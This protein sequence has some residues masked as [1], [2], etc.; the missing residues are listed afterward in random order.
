MSR[1]RRTFSKEFKSKV[2]LESLK[3]IDSLEVLAKKYELLP[4]QIS[5]WK[6]DVIKNISAVFVAEKKVISKDKLT[7]EQLYA[8]IGQLTLENDF[9]KKIEVRPQKERR[10]M[11]DIKEQLSIKKQFLLLQINR[12]SIYYSTKG[13][14]EKNLKMM[15]LLDQQYLLTPFYGYRKMTIWLQNRNFLVNKKCVKRLMELINWRTIYRTPLTTI[16]S[17]EDRKYP[18]LLKKGLD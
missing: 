10:R 15:R 7:V 12:N 9:L 14:S 8:P 18:Y 4:G 5:T 17:S 11:I 13:E 2:I 3:E 1:I 6:A 16:S